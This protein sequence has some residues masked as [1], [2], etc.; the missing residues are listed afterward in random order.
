MTFMV[1]AGSLHDTHARGAE[2]HPARSTGRGRSDAAEV[3]FLL[4]AGRRLA[5][6]SGGQGAGADGS[7]FAIMPDHLQLWSRLAQ[8]ER[9]GM[10][11]YE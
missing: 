10:R 7:R 9:Q 3:H 4:A 8:P 5:V 2:G 6:T 1:P 11:T